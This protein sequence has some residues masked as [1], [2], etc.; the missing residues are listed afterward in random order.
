MPDMS[1][2]AQQHSANQDDQKALVQEALPL[3]G[4]VPRGLVISNTLVTA[5]PPYVLVVLSTLFFQSDPTGRLS[6][7][8]SAMS[9]VGAVLGGFIGTRVLAAIPAPRVG[10]LL[11]LS[12][13]LATILSYRLGP[14]YVVPLLSCLIIIQLVQVIDI[15][16][17]MQQIER[18]IAPAS[19]VQVHSKHQLA[20]TLAALAAPLAAG[21]AAQAIAIHAM[22]LMSLVYIV[23]IVHWK[24]LDVDS[25]S[26]TEHTVQG[27]G[28]R[29]LIA[30]GPL[31]R[32]T[33]FRLLTTCAHSATFVA[34][35]F[36][37]AR[38]TTANQ[39]GLIQSFLLLAVAFG[40]T[41]GY[42]RVTRGGLGDKPSFSL[43]WI[44][45]IGSAA[46]WIAV[47]LTESMVLG[48][49]ACVV[50]GLALYCLRMAGVMVGRLVTP[51]IVFG[52]AVLVGDTISRFGSALIGLIV[53]AF[54]IR[55]SDGGPR[56][57]L[58][59]SLA[60]IAVSAMLVARKLWKDVHSH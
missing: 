31:R 32:L 41:S 56:L 11:A 13:L 29:D 7:L 51:P 57:I 38:V 53:S 54:L 20:M 12:G 48:M 2:I 16:N 50:H 9:F 59:G 1:H 23:A 26:S 6:S 30:H 43:I 39:A 22:A 60:F 5:A 58:V 40:F 25:S 8:A 33:I 47:A 52:Q 35:P 10:M 24:R 21:I 27:F 37:A 55:T 17:T 15:A 18:R 49:V 14:R 4:A 3:C 44:G 19:R 28:F 42:W 45:C 34:A 36:L 46:A